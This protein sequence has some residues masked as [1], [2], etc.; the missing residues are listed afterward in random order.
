VRRVAFGSVS[1]FGSISLGI[2]AGGTIICQTQP[3]MLRAHWTFRPV[4]VSNRV[5]PYEVVLQ[6]RRANA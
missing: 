6:D 3:I 4:V 2:L 1:T 5:A